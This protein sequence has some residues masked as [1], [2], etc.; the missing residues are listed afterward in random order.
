MLKELKISDYYKQKQS[1]PIIDVRSPGEFAK[2]H[3][4]NAVN[5][6]L[7]SDQERADVGT[8]YVQESKEK[9]I[10]QGYKYVEPKLE[11]FLEKS[12]E[13]AKG[14]PVAIHCWRGGMRSKSF[15]EHLLAKGFAEVFVIEKGYK[16]FRNHVLRFFERNFTLRIVGGYTGTGKTYMLKELK[17]LGEQVIDLEGIAHHKGSAFGAIGESSQPT[18]EQF[19]NNL[20]AE[21]LKLDAN[22]P[23]WV[24]DESIN[25]GYVQIPMALFKQIREQTVYFLR[26]DKEKRVEHLVNEYTNF[27][28]DVLA[29]AID[30][31]AKRIGRENAKAAHKA[32]AKNNYHEVAILALNYYDKA[33]QKGVEK[34]EQKHVVEISLSGIN[35][36]ANA[37]TLIK[38][39]EKHEQNKINTI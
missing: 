36:L 21:F 33:Y 14:L 1:I 7:F 17:N 26:V 15:A 24:E 5:I 8:I 10:E 29:A 25:I 19:E 38:L 11:Y 28:N 23:I 32:L 9:A 30:R 16:A 18:V 13:A 35:H 2:G 6:P 37:K 27:G 31:I 20:F 3:I 12:R 34:R 4:P 22:K 39:A